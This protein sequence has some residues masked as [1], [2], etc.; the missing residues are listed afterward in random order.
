MI[1]INLPNAWK[2]SGTRGNVGRLWAQPLNQFQ[3]SPYGLVQTDEGFLGWIQ[4]KTKRYKSV[5]FEHHSKTYKNWISPLS[6]CLRQCSRTIKNCWRGGCSESRVLPRL[7][8]D[9]IKTLMLNFSI[10]RR[11]DLS[12][13]MGSLGGTTVMQNRFIHYFQKTLRTWN[14]HHFEASCSQLTNK[15]VTRC[16]KLSGKTF[17]AWVFKMFINRK[18]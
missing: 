2:V 15:E 11:L 18:F 9:W 5:W 13:A 17:Q 6:P 12:I 14:A 4:I 16:F 1:F 8:E 7:R 10:L 3:G